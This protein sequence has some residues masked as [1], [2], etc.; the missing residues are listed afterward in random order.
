MVVL[1]NCG[2]FKSNGC[3]V[4]KLW[5]FLKVMVV[6]LLL[7]IIKIANCCIK[8]L[9]IIIGKIVCI[10]IILLLIIKIGFSNLFIN[11]IIINYQNWL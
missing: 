3:G 10:N 5:L 1:K 11:I 7:I 8:R 2:V 4:L 9:P 6:L